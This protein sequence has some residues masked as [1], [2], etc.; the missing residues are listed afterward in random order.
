MKG[1]NFLALPFALLACAH[2]QGATLGM[3]ATRD[4]TLAGIWRV[5]LRCTTELCSR[6][7]LHSRVAIRHVALLPA[8]AA[9]WKRLP[10]LVRGEGTPLM[11]VYDEDVPGRSVGA[12]HGDEFLV[13]ATVAA[14]DSVEIDFNPDVDHGG[15]TLLGHFAGDSV[16]GTWFHRSGSGG[17]GEF[18]MSRFPPSR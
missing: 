15:V 11:G 4:H 10:L 12:E 2:T 14:D 13:I 6:N 16:V 3:H 8:D 17:R 9:T 7:L 5:E 18:L 1:L